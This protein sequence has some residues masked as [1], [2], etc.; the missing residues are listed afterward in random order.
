LAGG[1]T[2]RAKLTDRT[3]NRG[4]V[5]G[6]VVMPEH[7]HLLI[8]EPQRRRL[9]DA[10]KRAKARAGGPLKPCFGLSG[11]VVGYRAYGARTI[12]GD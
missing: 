12:L 3:S 9:A 6:Y 7:V 4:W 1:P 11:E 5:S 8:G 2:G 10:L